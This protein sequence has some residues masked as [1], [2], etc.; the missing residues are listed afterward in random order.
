MRRYHSTNVSDNG[1]TKS[2]G[3]GPIGRNFEL[4]SLR[5]GI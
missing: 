2:L 3:E 1:P 5:D 4:R